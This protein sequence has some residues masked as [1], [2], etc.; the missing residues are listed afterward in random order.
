MHYLKDIMNTH[1]PTTI[2]DLDISPFFDLMLAMARERS[3]EALLDL[4]ERAYR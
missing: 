3:V 1:S 4:T 2:N